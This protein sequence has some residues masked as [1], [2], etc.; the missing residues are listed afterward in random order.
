MSNSVQQWL[1]NQESSSVFRRQGLSLKSRSKRLG[2]PRGILVI[3]QSTADFSSPGTRTERVQCTVC[4]GRR[5]L[6]RKRICTCCDNRKDVIW[7]SR[8]SMIGELSIADTC[9]VRPEFWNPLSWYA[10]LHNIGIRPG[11]FRKLEIILS[12]SGISVLRRG[13]ENI[14]RS[15]FVNRVPSKCE[16]CV[17]FCTSTQCSSDNVL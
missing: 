6:H 17:D 2:S 16:N 4:K 7:E 11:K 8:R 15:L 14:F 13:F 1:R 3:N 5:L 10:R 9:H 12:A